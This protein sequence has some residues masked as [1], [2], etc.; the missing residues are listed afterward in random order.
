MK[1]KCISNKN[2]ISSNSINVRRIRATALLILFSFVL[3][4][5]Y[6][7]MPITSII[8]GIIVISVYLFFILF[9]FPLYYKSCS[10]VCENGKIIIEN[11]CIIK[12]RTEIKMSEVQYCIIYSDPIQ[13][14]FGLC[15]IRLMMAG[16]FGTVR[17]I[18]VRNAN[19][20]K[21]YSQRFEHEVNPH[22]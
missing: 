1:Q 8:L 10:Y 6:V 22:E 21:K 3:G 18:S 7:F 17:E 4:G 19:K 14:F 16:T 12:S 5:L 20:I 11:G 13:R 15:T 9:Y 2:L